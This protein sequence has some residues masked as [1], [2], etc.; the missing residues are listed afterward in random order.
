MMGLSWNYR[1]LRNPQIVDELYHLVK[2]KCLKFVFLVETKCSR[3]KVETVRNKVDFD[4]S[5][6]VDSKGLSGGLAFMRN[7]IDDICLD[8]YSQNHIS[9]I[10]KRVED[11]LKVLITGFYGNTLTFRRSES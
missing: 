7:S 11:G 4:C 6:V 5:S 3:H 1:G 2:S 9:I 10:F 8:S